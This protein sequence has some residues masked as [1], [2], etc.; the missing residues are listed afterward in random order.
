MG[1]AIVH[2]VAAAHGGRVVAAAR[3]AGGLAVRVEL[4]WAPPLAGAAAED[5]VLPVGADTEPAVSG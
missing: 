3:P 2:A 1:L 5:T 4:P